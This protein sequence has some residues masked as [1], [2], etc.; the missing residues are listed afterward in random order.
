MTV[1]VLS[2]LTLVYFDR[3]MSRMEELIT[4]HSVAISRIEDC[5]DDMQICKGDVDQTKIL[6]L[7][8][9]R[10]VRM[11]EASMG[12]AHEQLETLGDR[13][14]GCFTET[15]R[16][17]SLSKTNSWSLGSEIQRVQ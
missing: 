16:V 9:Q 3:M 15:R 6:L 17:C 5:K 11:L 12:S 8:A 14:D 4:N 2:W 7:S 10:D 1:M 13:V